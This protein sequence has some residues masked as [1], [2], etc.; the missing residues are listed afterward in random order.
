MTTRKSPET[1]RNLSRRAVLL[2]A[3]AGTVGFGVSTAIASAGLPRGANPF[4][5][6]PICRVAADGPAVSDTAGG[7]RKK[8]TIAWNAAAVCSVS[9]PVAIEQGFFA[10]RGIDVELVSFG[11]STDQ[12]LEAIATG[13][14]DGGVG[15]ALRWLKP[16]E[17]GFD[18]KVTAGLHG[19]CIR[20]L[21][22]VGGPVQKL[23]DLKGK[24]VAVGDIAGP[25]K[26]FFSVLLAK[27]GID[28]AKDVD[29]RQYPGELL[30]AAVDKGE[31]QA[32]AGIDPRA[33]LW[34][35]DG[36][37]AEVSSNLQGE[38]ASRTCCIVGV[39]GSLIREDKTS[40]RAL[41]EGILEAAHW[42]TSHPVEAAK[43]FQPYAPNATAA[44]LETLIKTHT[45]HHHP[46][47]ADLKK[48]LTAYADELKLVSV[49]KPTT[50]TAKFAD[51]IYADVL[52]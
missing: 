41:T 43:A 13:K 30:R 39:R 32:I 20:L 47:G 38:F 52:A 7:P 37:L 11:G 31:A 42:I 2:G 26:N 48:E 3:G 46:V 12:L 44:D 4:A 8:L 51:K 1:V 49:I 34:L 21:A 17:Q 36:K 28:P 16:M 29:W 33:Y 25:D 18:V 40:A 50:D 9:L 15:M 19:G 45:H 5:G 14:A 27:A 6:S 24:V 22:P 10:K 35:K 23:E